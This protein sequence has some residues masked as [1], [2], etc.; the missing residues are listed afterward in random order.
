MTSMVIVV[1]VIPMS[2][3]V[4]VAP[5]QPFPDAAAVVAGAAAD[6]ELLPV[7]DAADWLE[8]EL[9]LLREHAEATRH[10]TSAP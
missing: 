9:E 8:L 5:L 7:D 1:G 3:D 2:D 4:R 6:V 10:T